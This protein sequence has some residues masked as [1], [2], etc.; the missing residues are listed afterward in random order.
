MKLNKQRD[1]VS[2]ALSEYN[3]TFKFSQVNFDKFYLIVWFKY[4]TKYGF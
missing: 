4:G 2:I 1:I 3:L